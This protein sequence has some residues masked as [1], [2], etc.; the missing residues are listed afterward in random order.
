MM[1]SGVRGPGL[2]RLT[3][4]YV[5]VCFGI[6]SLISCSSDAENALLEWEEPAW[7]A[8]QARLQDDIAAILQECMDRHGWELTIDPRGGISENLS[9]LSDPD[10]PVEDIEACYLEIPEDYQ[11][12]FD[13]EYAREILY[14]HENDVYLCLLNHGAEPEEPQAIDLFVEGYFGDDKNLEPWTAWSPHVMEQYAREHGAAALEQLEHACPQPY[15]PP[16]PS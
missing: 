5:A 3:I 16:T 6:L 10:A 11:V 7:F 15:T 2:P 13:V 1:R 8:E 9:E 4:A 14:Q 12:N